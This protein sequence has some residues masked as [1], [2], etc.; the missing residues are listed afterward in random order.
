[1][2]SNVGLLQFQVLARSACDSIV[3]DFSMLG[4]QSYATRFTIRHG[5]RSATP[6]FVG[7]APFTLMPSKPRFSADV[8]PRLEPNK[9]ERG[10]SSAVRNRSELRMLK[11]PDAECH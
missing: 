10:I 5:N 3:Y 2:H 11:S 7:N 8:E 9:C 6:D 4:L 1:M